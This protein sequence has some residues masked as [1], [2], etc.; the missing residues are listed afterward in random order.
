MLLFVSVGDMYFATAL[1][2]SL[3]SPSF[4]TWSVLNM[5]LWYGS[6]SMEQVME[7]HAYKQTHNTEHGRNTRTRTCQENLRG[8]KNLFEDHF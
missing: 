4:V 6:I 1:L 3:R 8:L 5:M 2:S 7:R